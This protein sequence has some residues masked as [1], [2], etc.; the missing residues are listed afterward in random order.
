MGYQINYGG[1]EPGKYKHGMNKSR[2]KLVAAGILLSLAL[3]VRL[4]IPGTGQRLREF[5]LPGMTEETV[6]AFQVMVEDM[7]TGTSFEDAVTAFCREIIANA[8][9]PES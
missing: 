1:P 4:V 2:V 7:R 3:G 6:T 5:L 8:E 9:L